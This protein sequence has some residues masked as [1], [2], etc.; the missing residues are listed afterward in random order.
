MYAGVKVV[1]ES[2]GVKGVQGSASVKGVEESLVSIRF[3]CIPY[4]A[5]HC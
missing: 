2:A 4:T 3:F 5:C 1:Q